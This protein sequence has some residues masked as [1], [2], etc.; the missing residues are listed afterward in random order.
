[1]I[2]QLSLPLQL[3]FRFLGSVPSDEALTD[4]IRVLT[5]NI[6]SKDNNVEKSKINIPDPVRTAIQQLLLPI[7]NTKRDI[8]LLP[9]IDQTIDVLEQIP[10]LIQEVADGARD[11]DPPPAAVQ[12]AVRRAYRARRTLI[13]NYE[14]DSFDESENV[15]KLLRESENL[16]RMRKPMLPFDIQ[17]VTLNG[18]HATPCIAPPRDIA[19]KAEDILGS[20]FSRQRLFYS[21]ADD[22]VEAVL[23]WLEEGQL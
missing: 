7:S 13:I 15:E 8:G 16:M 22:T 19:T 21:G 9:I 5:P 12:A 20:E 1:M 11:F 18:I 14:G 2:L 23:K 10:S 6:F 17:R 3:S 4:Y